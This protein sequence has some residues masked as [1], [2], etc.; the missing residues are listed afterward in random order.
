MSVIAAAWL[1]LGHP[2]TAPY[3]P[4]GP[5]IEVVLSTG[6][7]FVITTDPKWYPK[8]TEGILK[9]VKKGFYTGIKFHRVEDWVIQWGD[10]T[11]KKSVDEPGV[12]SG[13]SGTSLPFEGGPVQFERGVV[14]IASTGSG[15][16][17][18]SQL[19]VMKKSNASLYSSYAVL[20]LVTKGMDV[21]DSIERGATITRMS[22]LGAAKKKKK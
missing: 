17:G 3:S 5:Q 11:S 20:G 7:K 15:V 9:L 13:G 8:T 16:G 19:F 4:K 21:V 12:G 10:P 2:Q 6:K 1:L 14:G 22:V 18:D